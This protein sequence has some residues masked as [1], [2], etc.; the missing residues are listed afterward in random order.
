M[1]A[2]ATDLQVR[3]STPPLREQIQAVKDLIAKDCTDAELDLFS[4]VCERTGLDPFARQIYAIKRG[5]KMGVQTSIDGF[6][7]TAQRTK[8]YRGQLGP[9]WCGEDGVWKDVWLAAKPP[10]AARVGII[11]KDFAEPVWS[12]ARFADYNAGSPLW[13]KMGPTM[14]AK[15][16]EALGLRRCFPQEL[17]NVYTA[18]EMD[19]AGPIDSV[20]PVADYQPPPKP[21]GSLA[22]VKGTPR[23]V[24]GE[25]IP[26]PKAQ[27]TKSA[28]SPAVSSPSAKGPVAVVAEP[29]S[30]LGAKL[31]ASV[32]VDVINPK[33]GEVVGRA[34]KV[35]KA[36]LAKIHILKNQCRFAD[37]DW[38]GRLEAKY[39]RRSSGDLAEFQASDLIDRLQK[40]VDRAREVANDLRQDIPHGDEAED[41]GD[42]PE[43]WETRGDPKP[44]P[45]ERA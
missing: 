43:E 35:T 45:E 17:S 16:A 11:H 6:R 13:Q 18:E 23:G 28:E 15:C 20:T 10:A 36:Q 41:V 31:E 1:T 37:D 19:Q 38:R 33:T 9:F 40:M 5:G 42:V 39:G 25:H 34:P 30:T 4:R 26:A 7:L 3:Q 29:A 8:K 27:E 32:M 21:V 24:G 44:D 12:V 2:A 14:V 22:R